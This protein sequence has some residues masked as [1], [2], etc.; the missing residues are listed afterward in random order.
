MR[1]LSIVA[2]LLLA[3]FVS[4]QTPK[5]IVEKA[6]QAHGGA[7]A[8]AKTRA[9]IQKATGRVN[10]QGNDVDSQREGKWALPDRVFNDVEVTIQN[11]RN[12]F[13]LVLNGLSGWQTIDGG[14]TTEM[15]STTYDMLIDEAHVQWLCTVAPLTR[16]ELKLSPAPAAAV[17]GQQCSAVKV[18]KAGKPDATLYFSQANGLLLK[19]TFRGHGQIGMMDKEFI[20]SEHKET[21]GVKLPTKVQD[22]Q[23]GTKMG[24]WTVKEYKFVDKFESGTFKKP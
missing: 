13:T 11:K 10:F 19:A 22:F 8:L 3:G 17:N 23:A 4:A 20:F 21:A 9:M 6:I 1:T 24:D 5:E 16:P 7:E 15:S 14:A 12:K 2:S 18:T